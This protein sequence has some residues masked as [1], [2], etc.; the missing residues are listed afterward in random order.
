MMNLEK[1]EPPP[2]DLCGMNGS[3]SNREG[4]MVKPMD[5]SHVDGR[6]R[7]PGRSSIGASHQVFSVPVMRRSVL[8]PAVAVQVKAS[9]V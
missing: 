5:Q 7:P 8:T 9:P 4:R 6:P 1:M 3:S 2:L